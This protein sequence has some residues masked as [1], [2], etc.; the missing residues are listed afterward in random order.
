MPDQSLGGIHGLEP[1]S[2]RSSMLHREMTQIAHATVS[3]HV[4]DRL[5]ALDHH[6]F[7]GFALAVE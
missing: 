2:N 1:C 7:S 6:S 5:R 4:L 3:L